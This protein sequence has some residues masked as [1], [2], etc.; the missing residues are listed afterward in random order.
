MEQLAFIGEGI[1][2]YWNSIIIAI[3]AVAAICFYAAAYFAK[4]G[5][6]LALSSSVLLSVF[7]SIPLSRLIHWYCQSGSYPNLAEAM[8]DYTSGGYALLGVFVGCFLAAALIRMLQISKNLPAMLDCMSFGAIGIA[9]GRLASLFGAS[10]R[11]MIVSDALEFPFAYKLVNVVS[12]TVQNRLATFMIQSMVAVAIVA[13]LLLYVLVNKIRKK[14]IPNG[15]IFLIF[16]LCYCASQIVCDSTRY[17]ALVLRSNGFISM[18][19]VVSAVGL[20]VPVGVFMVR[21]VKRNGFKVKY[22]LIWV[23][24]GAAFGLACYME[25]IVQNNAHKAL[26]AYSTMSACMAVIVGLTLLCRSF[27]GNG[28]KACAS[29]AA[30]QKN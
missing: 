16:L 5:S 3:A 23:A 9:V 24:M 7:L 27:A 14:Q 2:I 1:F 21:L 13:G 29:V 30:E 17:D 8:T 10:D 26:M 20:L 19:Q 6:I 28:P 4:E 22:L 18:V 12:G 15:D 25:Y 11:G